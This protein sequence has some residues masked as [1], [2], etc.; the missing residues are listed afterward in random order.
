MSEQELP[1]Y[2]EETEGSIKIQLK[3]P[4]SID[5]AEVSTLS[6]REPTVQDQL[7]V[8]SMKG[9]PANKEVSMLANL[10]E[11]SPDDVKQMKMRNYRRLQEAYE[12]FSV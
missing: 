9:T 7:D 2:L 6:M 3:T 1:K 5:G 4:I 10:C 12:V 11:I 8:D